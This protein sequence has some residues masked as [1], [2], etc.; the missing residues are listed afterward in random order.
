MD[1]AKFKFHF[2]TARRSIAEIP[3]LR[4]SLRSLETL[5][6][7]SILFI[8]FSPERGENTMNQALREKRQMPVKKNCRY[9]YQNSPL[10]N[11]D[12]NSY[13]R[14]CGEKNPKSLVNTKYNMPK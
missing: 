9:L 7:L 5:R 11:S 10:R 13:V 8:V 3:L 14:L 4:D 12:K 1:Y 2:F 6:A